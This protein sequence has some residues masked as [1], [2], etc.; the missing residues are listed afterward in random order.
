MYVNV[1]AVVLAAEP[2][3]ETDK[4]L[5]LFT[6]E[7]GRLFARAAGARRPGAKLA[8]ATEPASLSRFRLWLP[9]GG[10]SARVTGGGLDVGLPVLR[11]DWAR[12]TSALFVCEWTERFTP[13]LQAH[14]E[15]FDLLSRS[16]AALER[17]EPV[18]VRLAFLIQFIALSGYGD[19]ARAARVTGLEDGTAAALD[20]WDFAGPLA[21]APGVERAAWAEEQLVKSQAP[22]LHRPLKSLVHQRVLGRYLA[23]H[24]I[25]TEVAR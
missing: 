16:L 9:E 11:R 7:K 10:A 4:R 8:A 3:S 23:K 24:Q 12:G 15:K 21:A 20:R 2:A 14:P 19:A 1:A 13:L 17:E 5:T 25:P 18:V 22:L 6:R